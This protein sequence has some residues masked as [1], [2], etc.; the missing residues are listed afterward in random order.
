MSKLSFSPL[1]VKDLDGILEYISQDN[2]TAATS[3]V[4]LLKEK[5]QLLAQFP[6]LGAPRNSLA[7]GL[8]VFS[9]SNYVIYYRLEGNSI[10]I[11]RVMHGARDMD[12][13]IE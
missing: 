5:C 9:V 8:R 7:K 11:E 3:F 2:P 1:A 6:L 10:R 12:S 13:L 4:E